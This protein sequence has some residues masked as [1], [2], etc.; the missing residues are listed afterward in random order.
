MLPIFRFRIYHRGITVKLTKTKE[1][2]MIF[3]AGSDKTQI[4][5]KETAFRTAADFSTQREPKGV[6]SLPWAEKSYCQL[7]DQYPVRLFQQ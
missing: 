1:N 2:E 5:C 6:E 3:K 4:A 7:R